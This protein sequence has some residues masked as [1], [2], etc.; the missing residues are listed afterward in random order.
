MATD[1][2]SG[3]T[4][5]PDTAM[6]TGN[7]EGAPGEPLDVG[8]LDPE[9]Q[10]VLDDLRDGGGDIVVTDAEEDSHAMEHAVEDDAPL[11]RER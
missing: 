9:E 8:L 7:D 1:P 2:E 4:E 5:L 11:P 10:V 6:P 3:S